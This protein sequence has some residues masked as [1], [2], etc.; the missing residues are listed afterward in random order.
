MPEVK[1]P[2]APPAS[3]G[4]D[5]AENAVQ[6][7][8]RAETT[9]DNARAFVRIAKSVGTVHWVLDELER[10]LGGPVSGEETIPLS[11]RDIPLSQGGQRQ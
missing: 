6:R 2:P 3:G 1:Y 9:L 8:V 11:L 7:A 10:I 5:V 4:K